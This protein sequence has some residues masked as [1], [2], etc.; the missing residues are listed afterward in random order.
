MKQTLW[1]AIALLGILL[2]VAGCPR[3]D[4][5]ADQPAGEQAQSAAADNGGA[6]MQD[7]AA[8][9]AAKMEDETA[10]GGTADG[11]EAAGEDAAVD[12][13]MSAEETGGEADAEA[14]D[15]EGGEAA[16]KEDE[17]MTET[18]EDT[19]RVR[20][21][22]NEGD[23]IVEVHPEWSPKGAAHWLELVEAG[24]YTDSPFFRVVDGFMAQA[25]FSGNAEMTA[26]YLRNGIP[27]EPMVMNN[28]KYTL[29]FGNTGEPNSR[30]THFFINFKDNTMLD[31]RTPPFPAFAKVVDG[32]DVVDKIYRTGEQPGS[33]QA[34]LSQPEGIEMFRKQ[35]P[36]VTFIEKAEII[37]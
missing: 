3:T 19:T 31:N 15:G 14:A 9:D 11:V 8:G 12:E 2:L 33:V 18:N 13:D 29:S 36:N 1:M 16:A 28:E 35:N 10:K 30:S 37:D 7:E 5:Y 17:T 24:F 22:T 34:M 4:G 6:D 27:D 25:G 32:F 26:T 21:V 20:L 23:I